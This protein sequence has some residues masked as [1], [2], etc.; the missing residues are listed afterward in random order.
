MGCTEKSLEDVLPE[1]KAG[2]IQGTVMRSRS[3]SLSLLS[4]NEAQFH[5]APV[6]QHLLEQV[7]PFADR[8]SCSRVCMSFVSPA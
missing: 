5:F 1:S 7:L 8:R 3:A 2:H 6:K 4:P